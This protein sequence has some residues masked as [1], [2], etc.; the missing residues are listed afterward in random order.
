MNNIQKRA[1]L[2]GLIIRLVMVLSLLAFFGCSSISVSSDYNGSTDFSEL[3]T[4]AWMLKTPEGDIDLG[5]VNQL[6]QER[7]QDAIAAELANKG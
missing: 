1:G 5:G 6:D 7:I 2:M 4:F 3:K